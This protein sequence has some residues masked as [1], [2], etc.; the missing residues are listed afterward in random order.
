MRRFFPLLC[1]FFALLPA[2]V[3]AEPVAVLWVHS[4]V[5]EAKLTDGHRKA[6]VAYL[7]SY[8]GGG[9][10]DVTYLRH[11]SGGQTAAALG[12]AVYDVIVVDAGNGRR[13]FSSGDLDAFRAFYASGKRNLL[14]DGT[15]LIRNTD[16]SS[17]S[18]FPGVDG[19]SAALTV[20]E[21][22][23]VAR[24]GG[25]IIIGADH[26]NFQADANQVAGALV[27]GAGFTGRTNPS[28]DGEFFGDGLLSEV[29][30]IRPVDLFR[31]WASIPSQGETS[32][33]SFT[34]FEG[35]PVEF[36]ALV[37]AADKPGGGRQRPYISA[38]LDPGPAR[39]SID[40]TEVVQ[41][42]MP[43]RVGPGRAEN[44]ARSFR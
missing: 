2:A 23:E 34:D 39:Y 38:T 36:R 14:L 13:M 40:S 12:A 21:I 1:V 37:A 16:Y 7:N 27:P 29:E 32:V 11:G 20:N 9:A 35:R 22:S 42:S 17:E 33:G 3:R 44:R 5:R 41:D 31:H 25:G 10:F 19:S 4:S 24:A 26:N 30:P 18:N 43:T 15:L 8:R 6:I 28:T